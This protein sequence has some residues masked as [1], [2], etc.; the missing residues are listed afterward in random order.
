MTRSAPGRRC[1]FAGQLRRL[2]QDQVKAI[3]KRG[4]LPA[5]RKAA[6][7]TRPQLAKPQL[8]GL[9]L[10]VLGCPGVNFAA[11]S[12]GVGHDTQVMYWATLECDP[13]AGPNT[14]DQVESPTAT[15]RERPGD[16]AGVHLRSAGP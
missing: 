6:A 9:Y 14:L 15:A 2:S 8:T 1:Q 10:A 3:G 4:S 16:T 13:G 7:T 12:Q 11:G 5:G